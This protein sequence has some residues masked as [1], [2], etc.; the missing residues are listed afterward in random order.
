MNEKSVLKKIKMKLAIFRIL[1]M[2][3]LIALVLSACTSSLVTD[4]P[5]KVIVNNGSYWNIS[6][7]QLN[8]MLEDKDFLFVNVHIPYYAEIVGTDFFIPFDKVEE[9]IS[10]FPQDKEAKIV[11][12]CQSGNMS[13]TA[14]KKLV[15][16]GYTNVWNLKTGMIAWE[17]EGYTLI[18]NPQ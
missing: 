5:E 16:L 8:K 11:L 6:S 3:A 18:R 15:E 7:A 10:Q 12:Y 9:N 13:A 2:V 14:A 1:S 17:A 4:E